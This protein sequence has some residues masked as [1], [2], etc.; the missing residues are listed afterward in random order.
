MRLAKVILKSADIRRMLD[1]GS[2]IVRLKDDELEL[3]LEGKAQVAEHY[4]SVLDSLERF[5]QKAEK[6]KV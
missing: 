2:V 4:A 1:G 5:I 3:E 6:K